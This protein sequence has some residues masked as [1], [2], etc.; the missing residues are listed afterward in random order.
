[1]VV[2]VMVGRGQ[3]GPLTFKKANVCSTVMKVK[4]NCKIIGPTSKLMVIIS[5][6]RV[7]QHQDLNLTTHNLTIGCMDMRGVV[8]CK[9]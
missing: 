4:N 9:D 5:A 6:I 1:M 2:V 7:P 3:G 8:P